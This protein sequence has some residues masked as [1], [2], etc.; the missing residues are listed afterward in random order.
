MEVLYI[1]PKNKWW[2][3]DWKEIWRFRDLFY[4]FTW[5]DVKV[6]YKQTVVG[7]LWAIFQPITSMVV[8]T[9]FFGKFAK[10][11]SD[12]IPYPIFVYSGLLFWNFFSSSLSE[13]SNSFVGNEHII[14]KVYFPRIILPISSILTNLVDFFIAALIL[15]CMVIYYGFVPHLLSLIFIPLLLLMTIFSALGIGLLYGSLNVKY[16]DVRYVLPFFM[17]LLIFITPVIYPVSIVSEKYRWIVGLNPMAGVISAA[18]VSILGT[19][20]IDWVLF[21]I[22]IISMLICLIA[23]YIYFRSIERYFADII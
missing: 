20:Q 23:G 5:R 12:G 11:P 7:A 22:S 6:K 2:K 4:F 16:R 8:F 9:I 13:V 14:T 17:Q 15:I 1:R 19:G 21:G 3:L 18:R 10:M